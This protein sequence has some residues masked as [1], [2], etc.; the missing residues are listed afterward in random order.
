MIIAHRSY[1]IG[2]R[3]S[4]CN[5]CVDIIKVLLEMSLPGIWYTQI[6]KTVHN[7]TEKNTRN[8]HQSSRENDFI[9]DAY[10][11]HQTFSTDLGLT[12]H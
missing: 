4:H 11:V 12:W 1:K 2:V 3:R 10:V 7:Q 8:T 9:E 5:V 6:A